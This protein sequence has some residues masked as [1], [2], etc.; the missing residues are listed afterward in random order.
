MNAEFWN[1]RWQSNQIAFHEGEV[2]SLL[3]EHIREL[4]LFPGE[5]VLVPLCGK[6]RDI[7]WLLS[8]GQKVVGVELVTSAVEQLFAELSL[9]PRISQAGPLRLYQAENLDVYAGDVF[10]LSTAVVGQVDAIYDR[11]ALVAPAGRPASEV[12]QAF[13]R[14]QR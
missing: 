12:R 11:A 8:Q 4:A 2:N 3:R 7:H 14:N 13:D 10:E 1:Q 6:T 5:R 9:E